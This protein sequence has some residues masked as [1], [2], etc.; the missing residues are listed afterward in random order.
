[1]SKDRLGGESQL[2]A[3]VAP[4]GEAKPSMI[5]ELSKKRYLTEVVGDFV[6][7]RS[8]VWKVEWNITGTIL[9]SSGDDGNMRLWKCNFRKNS[10]Y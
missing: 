9:S 8:E 6:E 2:K 5:P 3:K 7:H 4:Q 1:M 10:L